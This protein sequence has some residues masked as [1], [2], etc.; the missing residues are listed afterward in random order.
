MDEPTTLPT[1][2]RSRRNHSTSAASHD[3]HDPHDRHNP[4]LPHD[5]RGERT[6]SNPSPAAVARTV[7]PGPAART[8]SAPL[9]PLAASRRGPALL[10]DDHA[11]RPRESVTSIKDDP[12]FRNYQT[13]HSVSLGRELMSATHGAAGLQDDHGGA[14]D[15]NHDDHDGLVSPLSPPPRSAPRP[16]VETSSPGGGGLAEINIAV[17]GSAGVG[18]STL[19]QRAMG[20]RAPAPSITSSQR[21]PVEGT[22]YNVSLI[23]IELESFDIHPERRIQWPRQIN[24]HSVPR[25]DGA[26][27]L[28]DV[29]N[30]GSIQ[31][32]PQTLSERPSWR[33][34]E[35]CS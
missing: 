12:F 23:E 18:K 33:D 7:R 25:V 5:P 19:I 30:R 28:Y 14:H 34:C 1:R 31:E 24:G 8:S 11:H 17:I 16:S 6:L 22:M 20:L 4:D 13:P 21:M 15:P 3:L 26:L 9:V 2:V 10:D 29:M 32:L 27:L 35:L